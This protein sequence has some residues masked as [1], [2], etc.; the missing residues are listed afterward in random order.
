MDIAV[1]R[2][3][4]RLLGS[5]I[6]WRAWAY[7]A[8]GALLGLPTLVA[9]FALI[10]LGTAFTPV[11]IGLPVLVAVGF[12]GLAVG[13]L[14]RRRLALLGG[15]PPPSPHRSLGAVRGRRWVRARGGESATWREF[16]YTALFATGLWVLDFVAAA[17]PALSLALL[18][19]PVVRGLS[20]GSVR[21][22]GLELTSVRASLPLVVPALLGLLVG[23]YLVTLVAALHAGTARALLTG[24]S[25]RSDQDMEL[26]RSNGRLLDAF[27]AERRRIERDLHDG[28]QQ[29][30]VALAVL[31]DAARAR[32]GEESAEPLARA[33]AEA[34]T[35]LAELREL[36]RGIHPHVLVERGLRTAV[37]ELVTR[38]PLP[39]DVRIHG[40]GRL[41]AAVESTAYF[42]VSE[43]LTNV[44]KHSGADQAWV[45]GRVAGD[46]LVVEVGDR[47]P[48]GA[49][50]ERGSGLR[51]LADR[52]TAV[53]GRALLSSPPGGPT[54]VRVEIP[55]EP[56]GAGGR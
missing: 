25:A 13:A 39:V 20:P 36:V 28:V 45:R 30:L 11:L 3:P 24:T 2:N 23:L 22:L 16:A 12:S 5:A 54:V 17:I 55:C 4:V 15:P 48:G 52:V 46:L 33:H 14:E 10:A 44:V 56:G 6:P 40:V 53:G 18:A 35:T 27:D 29:R 37:A 43:A 51:G 50:P 9:L 47:G 26:I 42:A 21:Y 32:A 38:C 7:A 41:P 8:T 19:A 49:D 34:V 1:M 31:L